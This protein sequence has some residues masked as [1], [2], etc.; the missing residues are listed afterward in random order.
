LKKSILFIAL[1]LVFKAEAQTLSADRQYL[2]IADSLYSIGNYTNAINYYAKEGSQKGNLQIAR[3]YN[4]I[5][6]YDKAIVQ[7]E[8]LIA[9]SADLQIARFELGKLY[10]KMKRFDQGRKLFTSLVRDDENNPAYLYYQGE[11]FRELDQIASSLVAYKKAVA[12]DSTHLKSLFQLGKYFVIT[13]E[14]SQALHYLDKGLEFYA[15]DVSLIN[16]KGL[17]LFTNNEYEKAQPLFERLIALGEKKEFVYTK[18]AYCYFKT[19]EFEKA[20]STYHQLIKIDKF[21]QDAYFNLGQ[22][23]FKDKQI[24][25]AKYYV[26]KSI[27]VQEVTFEKEYANLAYMYRVEDDIKPA[28]KYYQLAFKEDPTAYR[29]YYQICALV[30]QSSQ[31]PAHKLAYY[32]NFIKKFGSD[33]PY[34]SEMV[35][36][37][38]SELKEALHFTT[39]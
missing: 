6:N 7:Y 21:N 16:L 26:K 19:W 36:K 27:A 37:R 10:L 13:R 1:I 29:N 32:E 12:A 38:I 4:S 20:K 24:D 30:D 2:A 35:L 22:V 14:T 3:A 23:F 5:G 8:N 33:K 25:S 31:D 39:D 9:E 15:A 28:L 18:L 17:A 34:I 11:S